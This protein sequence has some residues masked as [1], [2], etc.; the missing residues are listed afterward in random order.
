MDVREGWGGGTGGL[1]E[2][3]GHG[4]RRVV[5]REKGEGRWSPI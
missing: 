5:T 1:G 2:R 3:K 4:G